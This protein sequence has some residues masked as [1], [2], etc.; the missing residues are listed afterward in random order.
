MGCTLSRCSG[1][2]GTPRQRRLSPSVTRAAGVLAISARN[3]S[4]LRVVLILSMSSSSAFH[5]VPSSARPL[6]TRRRRHTSCSWRPVEQQLLV[7]GRGGVDVDGRVQPALG[8]LAVEPELHVAGA[9]ELLEDHLVGLRARLHE[10]RGQDRQRPALFDIARGTEE[11]LRRVD[12]RLVDAARREAAR[13]R[14]REV[15]GPGQPGDAVEDDRPR[16]GRPRPA[17]WPARGPVRRPGCARRRAGRTS[18]RSPRL[19]PTDACR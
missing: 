16:P 14:R 1:V 10:G 12:G 13:G 6:S 4:L 11:L 17:A 5:G 2:L 19:S 9:L 8:Q 7:A 3:S 15:V 18:R